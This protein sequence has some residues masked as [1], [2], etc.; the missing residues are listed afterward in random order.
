M[1][2]PESPKRRSVCKFVE[3]DDEEAENAILF[4]EPA[5][6]GEWKQSIE[7]CMLLVEQRMDD[8]ERRILERTA[9]AQK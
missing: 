6:V 3:I 8:I 7:R 2:E 9:A 1:S 4:K 5:T